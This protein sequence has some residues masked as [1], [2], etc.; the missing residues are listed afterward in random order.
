MGIVAYVGEKMMKKF[1]K[2]VKDFKKKYGWGAIVL[3]IGALVI[4][5]ALVIYGMYLS[6]FNVFEWVASPQAILIYI[7]IVICILVI[8][9]L[10]GLQ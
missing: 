4:G 6:G 1:R 9:I 2:W 5:G 10:W 8:L 3:P 7:I